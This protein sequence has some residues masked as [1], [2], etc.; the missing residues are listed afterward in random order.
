[1]RHVRVGMATLVAGLGVAGV[2]GCQKE[3]LTTVSCRS[4]ENCQAG[5]LCENYE[6]V[7]REAKACENVVDGNPIL[8]PS[9]HTMTF[10]TLDTPAALN[11]PMMLHNIGNCTLTLFEASL[12]AKDLGFT[13]DVCDGTFPREIFPGR[14]IELNVGFAPTVVRD[15]RTEL[16]FLSDDKEYPTLRM[17]LSANYIGSPKLVAAPAVVDFGY[18]AQGRL[19]KRLVQVTNQGTG[20]AAAAVQSVSLDPANTTDFALAPLTLPVNLP[21]VSSDQRAIL[22]I[23]V[24][25]TPRSLA[26]HMANLVITTSRGNVTVPLKGTSATPPQITVTPT[27]VD[28]GDVTLGTNNFKVV[29]LV[30]NGGAPLT[31]RPHWGGTTVTTDLSTS[32]QTLPPVAPGAFLEMQVAITATTL[33]AYSAILILDTNDP[34]HPSV[35]IPV[36][37]KG[38]AGPGPEVVKIEMTFDNGDDSAFDQDVRNVDMTLEHPF[39]YVCN[40]QTPAP[41]NWSPYGSC[42][43]LSFAPKEE[44]ER[45]VLSDARQDGTWRVMVNYQ[46]D[47]KSLPTDLL[48]GLLGISIDVLEEVLLGSTPVPGQDVGK[49]IEN[50]CL[51]HSSSLVSVKVYVNG[52]QVAER[53]GTLGRTGDTR[54]MLDVVR[55]N[56]VFTV[57]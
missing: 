50:L 42:S 28:L 52:M 24:R 20:T 55:A 9:P 25:Y 11:Q 22:P 49:L 37:A 19:V 53:T 45:I 15:A 33:G 18:V 7:P 23:E 43:W 8:Q 36:R 6:C 2:F 21:A 32:P 48:A 1:M 4:D 57:R 3:H 44:P 30:N 46:R 12:K 27:E 54:Y 38:V 35:S 51:S 47:C 13:C 17:P 14:S 39:G 41:M 56:G 34:Q 29:T 5:Y 10:G 31:V 40:K 26:A 16:V